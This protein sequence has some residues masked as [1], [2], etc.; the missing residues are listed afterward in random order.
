LILLACACSA[1]PVNRASDP[2][3]PVDHRCALPPAP[4][5]VAR[6]GTAVLQYWDIADE[7]LWFSPVIPD[8]ARYLA[9]RKAIRAAGAALVRPIADP[10]ATTTPAEVEMWRRENLNADVA[11][12]GTAGTVRPVHCLDAALFAYQ[13]ARH[14]ELVKPTEFIAHVLRKTVA[15]RPTLRIY[16]GAGDEMFPPKA[17]YGFDQVKHDVADGWRFVVT[18]HDH[19]IT[20]RGDRPALGPPVP[21]TNDVHLLRNITEDVALDSVWVTNGYFTIEIPIA[22]LVRYHGPAP[23]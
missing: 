9:Y 13:H 2:V 8:D 14:D 22:A 10:P 21:S 1:P 19:T 5:V 18:L 3:D 16:F 17:V 7:P 11:Y 20:K 12:S 6:D 15:G 23:R 4:T